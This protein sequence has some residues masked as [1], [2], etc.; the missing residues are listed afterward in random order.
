MT[1]SLQYLHV[2]SLSSNTLFGCDRG[3]GLGMQRLLPRFPCSHG[4]GNKRLLLVGG[5]EL[6]GLKVAHVLVDSIL[7]VLVE[8]A[9][10]AGGEGELVRGG[11]RGG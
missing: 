11:R 1:A 7:R 2:H 5:I 8:Q 6:A 9:C 4:W 3:F 10:S